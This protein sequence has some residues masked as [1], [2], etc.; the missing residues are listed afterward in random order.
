MSSN[1]SIVTTSPPI[2]SPDLVPGLRRMRSGRGASSVRR[3]STWLAGVV[4]AALVALLAGAPAQAGTPSS[5]TPPSVAARPTIV[6][7]HGAFSGPSA[8]DEVGSA[9]RKAALAA[10]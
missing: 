8:W 6:L 1:R 4:L 9:L 5:V 2:P 10:L 3:R 7:V